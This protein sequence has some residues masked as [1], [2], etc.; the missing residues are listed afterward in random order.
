MFTYASVVQ[1][2]ESWPS[3]PM[4]REMLRTRH[5]VIQ[6]PADA[7]VLYIARF[8]DFYEFTV[9][10]L[11]DIYVVNTFSVSPFFLIEIDRMRYS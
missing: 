2:L 8:Y 1:W 10:R 3:K 6:I 4:T 9:E 11:I 5:S 7:L